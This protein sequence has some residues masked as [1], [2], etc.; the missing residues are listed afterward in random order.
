MWRRNN[1]IPT[2]PGAKGERGDKTERAESLRR[3][4]K[5]EV[6]KEKR[7]THGNRERYREGG[8]RQGLLP[9]RVP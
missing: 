6:E 4:G 5:M 7:E 2:T 1:C 8:G 3:K 9:R